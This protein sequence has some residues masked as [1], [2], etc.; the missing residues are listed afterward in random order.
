MK[1]YY[2]LIYQA[3]RFSGARYCYIVA[4]SAEEAIIEFKSYYP[5]SNVI[6]IFR[7]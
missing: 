3:D 6:S 1:R 4:N 7:I 2:E 5:S